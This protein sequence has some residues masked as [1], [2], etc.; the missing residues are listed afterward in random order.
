MGIRLRQKKTVPDLPLYGEHHSKGQSDHCLQKHTPA[1]KVLREK[2]TQKG[3]TTLKR[4]VRVFTMAISRKPEIRCDAANQ[5]EMSGN[6]LFFIHSYLMHPMYRN[7]IA[8]THRREPND[9]LP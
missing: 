9:A 6:V 8:R 1:T 5:L 3:V 4:S 2:N 7:N